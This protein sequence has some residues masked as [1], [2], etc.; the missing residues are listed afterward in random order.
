M[1]LDIL[2]VIG[3]SLVALMAL[4]VVLMILAVPFMFIDLLFD[5]DLL[6]KV[7]KWGHDINWRRAITPHITP[8]YLAGYEDM[9]RG[10]SS[11]TKQH[12][13]YYMDTITV[14]R[15]GPKLDES[16]LR[17]MASRAEAVR[18]FDPARGRT[19]SEYMSGDGKTWQDYHRG[20]MK[21]LADVD[22]MQV[23]MREE[24]RV[25]EIRTTGVS[26]IDKQYQASK[27]ELDR[28]RDK[29][30]AKTDEHKSFDEALKEIDRA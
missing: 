27:R 25:I 13:G 28:L 23:R 29:T 22:E 30:F 19:S 8:A 9:A 5:L 11:H 2:S 18:D 17:R 14:T 16:K 10:L 3:F 24:E 6:D 4:F 15:K 21:L 12:G 1:F 26:A 20:G 7:S